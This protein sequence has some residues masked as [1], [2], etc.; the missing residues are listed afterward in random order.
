MYLL[1]QMSEQNVAKVQSTL[2]T[3]QLLIVSSRNFLQRDTKKTRFIGSI[4][5]LRANNMKKMDKL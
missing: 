4:K 5:K 2:S 3:L 1:K